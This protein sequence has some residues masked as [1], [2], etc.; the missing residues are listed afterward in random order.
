MIIESRLDYHKPWPNKNLKEKRLVYR[1]KYVCQLLFWLAFFIPNLIMYILVQVEGVQY[2]KL[3]QFQRT[4]TGAQAI[5][6]STVVLS[7]YGQTFTK[8]NNSSDTLNFPLEKY[9]IFTLFF[10]VSFEF[11]YYL[12]AVFVGTARLV[13]YFLC[14]ALAL[15]VLVFTVYI[16]A[17]LMIFFSKQAEVDSGRFKFNLIFRDAQHMKNFYNVIIAISY[18]ALLLAYYVMTGELV[19]SE[20][21]YGLTERDLI[22]FQFIQIFT[23]TML[24]VFRIFYLI[25]F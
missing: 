5:W 14:I 20:A 15:F 13:F 3:A 7:M 16:L 11:C 2:G 8:V 18:C 6:A 23:I 12:A 9:C 21:V 4:L 17:R 19:S 25:Y 10:V 24:Q 22:F 1:N